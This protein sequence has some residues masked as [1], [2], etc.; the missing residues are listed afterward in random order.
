[1]VV[2]LQENVQRQ[3]VVSTG[4][5]WHAA[6]VRLDIDSLRALTAIV[7]AG[8]F[9]GAAER[10]Q[11]TQSAVSWKIKRLEERIGHSVLVRDGKTIEL[12]DVGSDLLVHAERILAAHDEAVAALTNRDLSGTVHLG[13]ND[14]PELSVIADIIRSF[15]KEH[16]LVAVHTK[17]ATSQVLREQLASGELGVA[18]LQIIATE[19]TEEDVVIRRDR[20]GWFAS[21]ELEIPDPHA[22]PLITFGPNCFYRPVAEAKLHEVGG[23]Y[24]VTVECENSSGVISAVE[25]GLGVALLNVDH[26]V[27]VDTSERGAELGLPTDLP[28]VLFVA[29]RGK[30]QRTAAI[31][32]LQEALVDGLRTV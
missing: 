31:R 8:T 14:E 30:Y 24:Q 10:L 3:R 11:L 23:D 28:V 32:A 12:T 20:V 22:V 21:P 19:A 29:R 27:A 5:I 15:R 13:T 1:M 16:P 25:A 9:T 4:T 26:P 6:P 18:L 17:M 2:G 7:D